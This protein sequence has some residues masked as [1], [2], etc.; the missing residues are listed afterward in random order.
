MQEKGWGLTSYSN[1]QAKKKPDEH[2]AFQKNR[3]D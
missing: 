3:I 2:R 1:S